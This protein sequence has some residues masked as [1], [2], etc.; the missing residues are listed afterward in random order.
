VL[1]IS[2]KYLGPDPLKSLTVTNHYHT[3]III[4]DVYTY[5]TFIV[6]LNNAVTE[7]TISSFRGKHLRWLIYS[8]NPEDNTHTFCIVSLIVTTSYC[9][10][11]LLGAQIWIFDLKSRHTVYGSETLSS[12]LRKTQRPQNI[13]FWNVTPCRPVQTQRRFRGKWRLHLLNW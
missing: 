4:T 12:A 8:L 3:S 2:F 5:I 11:S 13:V 10:C 9:Q 6:L 7:K 1:E